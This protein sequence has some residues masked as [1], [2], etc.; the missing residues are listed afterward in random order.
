LFYPENRIYWA[1]A[2]LS[3]IESVN[4]TGKERKRV[5]VE[6]GAGLVGLDISP[7]YL[8]YVGQNK[9]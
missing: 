2:D 4:L 1:D 8:Y 7:P 9:Q 6:V 5:I 3:I